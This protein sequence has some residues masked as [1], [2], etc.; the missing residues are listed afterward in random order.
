VYRTDHVIGELPDTRFLGLWVVC[1]AL[2]LCL[3]A[4]DQAMVE[5][6]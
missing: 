6:D 3:T 1:L 4:A 5:E 2:A